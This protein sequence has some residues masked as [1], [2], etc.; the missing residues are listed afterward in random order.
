M[1]RAMAGGDD[2]D[3]WV[4]QAPQSWK[5]DLF[6]CDRIPIFVLNRYGQDTRLDTNERETKDSFVHLLSW[7][8]MLHVSIAIATQIR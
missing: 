7:E 1:H 6:F 5:T 4:D 3:Q 2:Y 8:R